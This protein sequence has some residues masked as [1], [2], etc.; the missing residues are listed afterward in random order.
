VRGDETVQLQID[1]NIINVNG[2]DVEIDVP[3]M[4]TDDRTFVPVRAVSESFG[5]DVDWDGETKTVIIKGE[6]K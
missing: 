5:C 6:T 2:T 4:I 3:A 1:S